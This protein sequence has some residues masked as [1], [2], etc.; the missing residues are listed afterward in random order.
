MKTI[1]LQA[2]PERAL[3]FIFSTLFMSHP[4]AGHARINP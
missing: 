2:G 1:R 4:K 3:T